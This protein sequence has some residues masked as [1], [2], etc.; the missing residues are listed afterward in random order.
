M[1]DFIKKLFNTLPPFGTGA[2][3]NAPD[4]R[5]I[6]YSAK[7]ALSGS[8]ETPDAYE[9]DLSI[10]SVF[11]Q[12]R[13]GT[14]VAHAF[15]LVAM[16]LNWKE[17]G[18]VVIFS[19]RKFY[20]WVRKL[21]GMKEE[22]GQGL[23]PR[24]AGKTATSYGFNEEKTP[25]DQT[26]SHAE[27]VAYEHTEADKEEAKK[28][29][30]KGYAFVNGQD[31]EEICQALI[32]EKLVMVSMPSD[33][34]VKWSNYWVRLINKLASIFS[35]RHYIVI[36]KYKKIKKNG[37]VVDYEFW[38]RNSWALSWG[39][40]GNGYVLHS[41][42][43]KHMT[44][45]IT[46]TDLPNDWID[47]AQQAQYIFLRHLK[48]GMKGE[49]VRQLQ[50]RLKTAGFFTYPS[51]TDY[52]GDYTF[53]ALVQWQK[54]NSIPNTGYFGDLSI[55]RM[56]DGQALKPKSKLDLWI[57]GIRIF[58]KAKPEL[59]NI[60]NIKCSSYYNPKAVGM[61]YRGFCIFPTYQVG[62]EVLRTMLVN[63]ATGKSKVYNPEMSI[64]DF[65]MKY[66]PPSD[67]NPTSAYAN[68]VAKHIGVPVTTKIK[69]LVV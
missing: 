15:C 17:T 51:F 26:L 43:G 5:D 45:L 41:D 36:F 49:D 62:Y 18:K 20:S 8:V 56:N 69:T 13:L 47:N 46:L 22:W 42:M 55:A 25:D 34:N 58:E 67:N 32:K 24:D 38:F 31:P 44:D 35:S 4:T 12:G 23:Y 66:A 68:F 54:A 1:L 30:A 33:S 2:L 29:R 57:D 40:K 63:A 16:F 48:K 37:E 50:M 3:E 14:C 65:F 64:Y 59:N 52:F 39:K 7:V 10:F 61:D 27:Y 28:F 21:A 11:N 60:G 53:N 6:P 9:T 19:R